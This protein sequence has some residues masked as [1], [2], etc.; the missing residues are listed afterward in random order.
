MN[1]TYYSAQ[2]HNQKTCLRGDR[3]QNPEG[4]NGAVQ[5]RNQLMGGVP[6][7][8]SKC[9]RTPSG[10]GEF[11]GAICCR[12]WI[13][14]T[15]FGFFYW[16][17]PICRDSEDVCKSLSVTLRGLHAGLAAVSRQRCKR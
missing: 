5:V 12:F 9:E 2:A 17:Q 15:V 11:P 13:R 14:S 6:H 3:S 4:G 16:S 8:S 7:G 10:C 1:E